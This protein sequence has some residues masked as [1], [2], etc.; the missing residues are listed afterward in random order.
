MKLFKDITL[1][2]ARYQRLWSNAPVIN[3][4]FGLSPFVLNTIGP[5]S[6]LTL[7]KT[8]RVRPPLNSPALMANG[9]IEYDDHYRKIDQEH[10]RERSRR[11]YLEEA[12][13]KGG[14]E[15][16]EEHDEADVEG[17]EDGEDS[18]DPWEPLL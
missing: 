16:V 17:S 7:D 10:V 6:S 2:K 13:E 14:E 4:F 8:S 1:F 12:E 5:R 3:Y 9:P 11:Y 18:V 15:E